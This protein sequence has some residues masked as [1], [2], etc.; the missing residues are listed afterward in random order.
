MIARDWGIRTDFRM[1]SG[2]TMLLCGDLNPVTYQDCFKTVHR[3]AQNISAKFAMF[4]S[5][6]SQ[7]SSPRKSHDF[8][9]EMLNTA[10]SPRPAYHASS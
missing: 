5:S 7:V 2:N 1:V 3:A 8:P 4:S 10:A 6:F 9:D